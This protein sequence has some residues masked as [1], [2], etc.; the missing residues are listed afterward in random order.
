MWLLL[1]WR[2]SRT[3]RACGDVFRVLLILSLVGSLVVVRP[4]NAA[5]YLNRWAVEIHGGA[6]VANSVAQLNGF[7]NLG[8]VSRSRVQLLVCSDVTS[9]KIRTY[10]IFV[11][12]F[13]LCQNER[14]CEISI[15]LA[16]GNHFNEHGD[17][18]FCRKASTSA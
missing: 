17:S 2:L 9:F 11:N 10:V 8:Q 5:V 16:I 3:L 12:I 18:L 15:R 7:R 14:M 6:E 1:C 4:L 13:T